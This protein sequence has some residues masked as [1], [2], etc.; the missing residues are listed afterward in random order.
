MPF[1]FYTAFI[2]TIGSII[3]HSYIA[4]SRHD[5]QNPKSLSELAAA[6][7]KLLRQFRWTALIN[8]T[9]LAIT[10]YFFI[11]PRNGDGLAQSV[12]WSIEYLGGILMLI[13]PAKE[14]LL[15][16]HEACALAMAIGMFALACL[17]LPALDGFYFTLGLLCIGMMT[18]F[19]IAAIID[20]KRIIG[21]ELI[22]IYTSHIT[23]C[24]AAFALR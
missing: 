6:E 7:S 13:F 22:F 1:A 12:A 20:K 17:F 16:L 15:A 18:I 23:I 14:R 3:G 11:A 9:L 2:G 10:V 8:S 21:H 19:G 4:L 5:Q 24:I